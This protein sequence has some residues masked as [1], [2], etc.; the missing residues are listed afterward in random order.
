MIG[1]G[2]G[3]GDV[4]DGGG[5]AGLG[6]EVEEQLGDAGG[7]VGVLAER[8]D[9]PDLAEVDG[10]GE[11]G[12]LLVAG[13][14]LD[15]LDAAALLHCQWM[16]RHWLRESR[17]TLGMVM[18]LRICFESRSHRR[19]VFA[20]RMPRLG[21]RMVMGSTKSDVRMSLRSQSML[22]PWGENCSPRM[23][24]RPPTSSGHSWMMLKSASVSTRRPGEVPTAEPM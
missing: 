10:R 2:G 5:V 18:V 16:S 13:D 8:V 17:L 14:E 1:W 12:A 7:A 19:R 21:F 20:R 22:R 4:L 11:S 23:L 3:E 6:A 24:S 15:V 9:D